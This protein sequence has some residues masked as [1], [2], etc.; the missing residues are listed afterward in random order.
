M[1]ILILHLH[2]RLSTISG[3][4]ARVWK[5][6][7]TNRLS[8]SSELYHWA[9]GSELKI[10]LNQKSPNPRLSASLLPS[11]HPLPALSSQIPVPGPQRQPTHLNRT[12]PPGCFKLLSYTCPPRSGCGLFDE[13]TTG[14]KIRFPVGHVS[15][16]QPSLENH[17]QHQHTSFSGT[18]KEIFVVSWIHTALYFY[19][20]AHMGFFC[21]ICIIVLPY[22]C[23]IDKGVPGENIDRIKYWQKMW[24]SVAAKC[25]QSLSE[26]TTP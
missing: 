26:T 14:E 24:C 17:P 20:F 16:L 19:S 3:N 1:I 6:N 13:R 22:S 2:L 12:L 23:S 11:L 7:P 21:S 18:R 5:T 4:T 15:P 25:L 9:E 8:I 10:F